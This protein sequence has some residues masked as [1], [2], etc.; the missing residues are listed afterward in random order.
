MELTLGQKQELFSR[1]LGRLLMYIYSSGYSVRMG[2]CQRTELQSAINS[3]SPTQ[4]WNLANILNNSGYPEL[5]T[6][7]KAN[8]STGIRRSL[9]L[10]KLAADLNIF[11]QGKPASLSEYKQFGDFW[12]NLDPMA[13]WGGDFPGDIYHFSVEHEGIK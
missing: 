4:K 7:L 9:H 1:L 6:I 10:L 11:K 2:E 12:K 8:P 3:Y 13:R 5:S